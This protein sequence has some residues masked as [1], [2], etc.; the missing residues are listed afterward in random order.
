MMDQIT[1][2]GN[3]LPD[4]AFEELLHRMNVAGDNLGDEERGG[5][6]DGIKDADA[7]HFRYLSSSQ[8][9]VSP[10]TLPDRFR[11]GRESLS[12]V[13]NVTIRDSKR[14]KP[15]S[16]DDDYK[17]RMSISPSAMPYLA[18]PSPGG[19][20]YSS[21]NTGIGN[22]GT[23]REYQGGNEHASTGGDWVRTGPGW[24]NNNP[25]LPN[26]IPPTNRGTP[27]PGS[28]SFEITLI[29]E[30]H[31]IGH[32]VTEHMPVVQLIG[33]AAALFHLHASDV[34]LLLFGIHPRTIPREN[35]LSDPPRVENGA[36][37]MVFT[38]IQPRQQGGYLPPAQ[39]A[40]L[41]NQFL[42][43]PGPG[44]GMFNAGSKML[45]NFKLPKFDGTSRY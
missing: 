43:A 12:V 18:H 42:L 6:H 11:A 9:Q 37:V 30:G 19:A 4:P 16:R 14:L 36:T 20:N 1:E 24:G 8:T 25:G 17:R 3:F 13:R 44:T 41:G 23:S 5:N 27:S 33:E 2:K 29:Y 45:G 15:R 39:P 35:R 22:V 26:S 10:A 31:R 28:G 40:A 7:G 21:P 32:R 38:I 34:L